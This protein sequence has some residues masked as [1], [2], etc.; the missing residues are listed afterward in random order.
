M[1][2]RKPTR[3][4]S[5]PK[6]KSPLEQEEP[7]ATDFT[8]IGGSP[9]PGL[10]LRH[11]LRGH[12]G[13]ITRIAWSPDGSYLASPSADNTIRIWDMRSGACMRILKDHTDM[14]Y[15]VAWSPDGQRLASASGDNT[16]RLWDAASGKSTPSFWKTSPPRWCCSTPVIGR[17][18]SR[19]CS[20]GWS[21]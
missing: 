14:I 2:E 21:N 11:V 19:A 12:T 1:P 17:N 5:T 18:R 16:L 6:P 15:S 20:S 4:P 13:W 10:T 9:V 7:Q 3:Q 8:E